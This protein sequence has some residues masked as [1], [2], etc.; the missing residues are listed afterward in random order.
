MLPES[1]R[2]ILDT[3][4]YHEYDIDVL[5]LDISADPLK[6]EFLISDTEGSNDKTIVSMAA[7]GSSDFYIDRE[8]LS[9]Y[10]HLEHENPLLWKFKDTQCELYVSG[11]QSKQIDKVIFDLLQIHF[12]LFGQ[13][14]SFDLEIVKILNNGHGLLKKG[15]KKLLTQFADSLNNNGIATSIISERNPE[16]EKQ[17][18]MILF[19]GYSY[20]IADEFKFE[21]RK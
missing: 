14:V 15:S 8:G 9:S 1:L 4:D 3:I 21:A 19:L 13:Y 10:I 5:N 11:G 17:G 7:L 2:K 20:V 18:L 12:S 16:K 6:M